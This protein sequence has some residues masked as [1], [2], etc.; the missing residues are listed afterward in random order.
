MA[1]SD[2]ARALSPCRLGPIG[3]GILAWA[4]MSGPADTG[5]R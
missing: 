2:N 1:D 5:V 3:E 4:A